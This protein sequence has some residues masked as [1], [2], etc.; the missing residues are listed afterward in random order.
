MNNQTKITIHR[1]AADVFEAFVSPSEIGGFWFSSS[2]ARWEQGKL[3]TLK[4][5]EYGAQ[6]DIRIL[7]L[8]EHRKIVFRW[9]DGDEGHVVTIV[10]KNANPTSTIVE[11]MEAGFD[12]TDDQIISDLL[13][14]KEGWV[15]M[16][17]CLKG[18]LEFGVTQLRASLV[19]D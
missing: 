13:D 18:Y 16:L 19:K 9:G 11:V 6:G 5:D 2:S 3:I 4:Y 14:N 7:E 8:V 17:T 15:Y 12:D 10:L 1:P